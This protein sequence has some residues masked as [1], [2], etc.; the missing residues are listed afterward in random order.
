MASFL[1]FSG[2]R[3]IFRDFMLHNLALFSPDYF[4]RNTTPQ[5]TK[6][7]NYQQLQ[8]TSNHRKVRR[9]CPCQL[10]M[11]RRCHSCLRAAKPCCHCSFF[12]GFVFS[13]SRTQFNYYFTDN[14][15]KAVSLTLRTAPNSFRRPP[16]CYGRLSFE[17]AA[18]SVTY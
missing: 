1:R 12:V 15:S 17:L 9:F 13:C 8:Q 5:Q 2:S 4:Y 10:V 7:L 14:A 6:V 3:N 16:G 11:A 18:A